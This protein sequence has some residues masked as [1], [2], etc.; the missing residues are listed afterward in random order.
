MTHRSIQVLFISGDSSHASHLAKALA[1]RQNPSFQFQWLKS[2][3]EGTHHL[4]S[5]KSDVVLLDLELPDYSGFDAYSHFRRK[6]PAHPI[7]V[8]ADTAQ[9]TIGVEAVMQG[10]QDYLVKGQYD[11]ELVGRVLH[12][13]IERKRSEDRLNQLAFYDPLT[14]L[15]NRILFI[16]RLRQSLMAA[17][18]YHQHVAILFLD[19][20]RFRR[21]NE[22]LGYALGDELLKA[23]AGRLLANLYETDTITRLGSDEFVILL[24]KIAKTSH[25]IKVAS[26]ILQA[27]SV[28]FRVHNH[29]LFMTCSMGISFFPHDGDEVEILLK[30]ADKAMS[31]AK[32]QGRN[33]FQLYSAT[34]NAGALEHFEMEN[35]L[36]YAAERGELELFYQPQ[37]DLKTGMIVGME[38]LIRWFHPLRGRLAPSEFLDLAEETGLILPIGEWVLETACRQTHHWR[39]QGFPNLRVAVNISDLQ[40][41]EEN[42]P[43][44][45][46]RVLEKT[47]LNPSFLELE[48]TENI[49]MPKN[50]SSKAILN[51]LKATG[52]KI[53]IDDFGTGYSSLGTLKRFPIHTLK[54]DQSFVQDISTN[55]DDAAI[56]R[57]II[58]MAHS[59][60]LEVV[61][62]GIESE[63]QLDFFKFHS[64]DKVQGFLYSKPLPAFEFSSFL[65]KQ[66]AG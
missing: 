47:G 18:R 21:I 15:P 61:A 42:F 2:L 65:E 17:N 53:A 1:D 54:I 29:E 59:L 57:A 44:V 36:R 9:K 35:H 33:N 16:D 4:A 52:V 66:A 49:M 43:R 10:A 11:D 26:K 37:I 38:A 40:F 62:E 20:D 25:A 64:C 22:T 5:E 24:P 48:L 23:V 51:A 56:A 14:H 31:L 34:M 27:F 6:H 12:Y 3:E 19:L 63:A 28:P 50:G 45:I 41:R 58:S 32:D 60:R 39:Q 13:A 7:V 46:E 8:L 55:P 30:N